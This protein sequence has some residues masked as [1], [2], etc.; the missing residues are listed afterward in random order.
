MY[1]FW[2][3][4]LGSVIGIIF[5]VTW[6]AGMVLANTGWDKVFAIWPFYA[7]YLLIQKIMV[8][9]GWL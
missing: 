8:L 7:W 2:N 4:L 1:Q 5:I 3:R 9:N 6:T